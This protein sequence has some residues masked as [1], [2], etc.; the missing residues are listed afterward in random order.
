M[1]TLHFSQFHLLVINELQ[2]ARDS[3]SSAKPSSTIISSPVC[4]KPLLFS[5]ESFNCSF[6][7]STVG[8]EMYFEELYYRLDVYMNTKSIWF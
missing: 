7:L 6:T 1:V 4:T 8:E 2:L 5:N 3:G